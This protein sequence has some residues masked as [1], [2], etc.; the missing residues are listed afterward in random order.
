MQIFSEVLAMFS[1]QSVKDFVIITIGT[2]ITAS[3]VY[4]FMLPS[5]ITVGSVS[6]LAL[7]LSNYIPLQVSVIT[8]IINLFLLVIGYVFVGR[9]FAMRTVYATILLPVI[10]WVF[11]VLVPDLQSITQDPFLDMVGYIFLVGIGLALLFSCNASTGGIEVIAKLMN[12]YLRMDL[13]QAMSVSGMAVAVSSLLC[14]DYK[15]VF[16]SVIGT[17]LGGLVLDHFIFGMN[18][19]RKVCIIS[20]KNDEIIQFILH[21]LHSGASIYDVTGAYTGE[22][23]KEIN[24]IVNDQEYKHLMNYLQKTDPKAFI[25]VY[26]VSDVRYQPKT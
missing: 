5:N 10:L 13:G 16:L 25:T 11:E 24:T 17:Y 4:F 20:E 1:K 12:K 3:A 19:K 14:Y 21:D 2:L 8:F 23:H 15:T 6:A 22:V 26:S 18:I 7:V 9:E